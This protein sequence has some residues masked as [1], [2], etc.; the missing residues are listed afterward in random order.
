MIEDLGLSNLYESGELEF[1]IDFLAFGDWLFQWRAFVV[2][3]VF[4]FQ[5]KFICGEIIAAMRFSSDAR[6]SGC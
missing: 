6:I 4:A 5:R 2:L 1:R 3:L